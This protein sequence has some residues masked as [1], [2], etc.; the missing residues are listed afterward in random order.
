MGCS[1]DY[2]FKEKK[3]IPE[4]GWSYHEKLAFFFEVSDTAELHNLF[5][6]I[7]HVETFS[8]QNIYVNVQTGMKGAELKTNTISLEL[9]S[10]LGLPIGTC[11]NELCKTLIPIQTSTFFDSVGTYVFEIEQNNR[12]NPLLGIQAVSFLIQKKGRKNN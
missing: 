2:S 9:F 1:E 8:T 10:K 4:K 11:K 6:E 3:I 5:L 12:A 7:E